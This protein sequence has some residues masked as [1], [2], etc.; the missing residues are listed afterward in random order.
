MRNRAFALSSRAER[1]KAKP[2]EGFY[3]SFSPW[4][5][6]EIIYTIPVSQP[7]HEREH[8]KALT[9]FPKTEQF[10]KPALVG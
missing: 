6:D 7:Y 4:Q 9:F 8:H 5:N 1:T 10:G 2:F 3:G